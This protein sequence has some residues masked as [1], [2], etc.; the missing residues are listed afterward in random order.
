MKYSEQL[1]G[2]SEIALRLPNLLLLIMYM[3][4]SYLIFRK[5]S[6]LLT[7]SL[8]I[9]LCTNTSLLDFF[10]LA[11]GY[12]MSCG[13]MLMSLYH[14]IQSFDG[15]K[16]KNL[17]FFHLGALLA[18][19]SSFS[20]LPFYAT[21][22]MVYNILV[23]VDC[24]FILKKKFQ[25]LRENKIHGFS[26]LIVVP[27]L[28]EPVRRV[29]KFNHL[30]FGGKNGFFEDTVKNLINY[31]LNGIPLSS[32]A[33][34]IIQIVFTGIILIPFILIIRKI[35]LR[36]E[37]FFNNYK[38]LIISNFSII[39]ISLIL[40]LQH[41]ILGIDYPI[42]RF[43]IFLFPLFII[44]FGFL[45][46]Y[47]ISSGSKKL[48]PT[49]AICLVLLSL[50][51]IG[52]NANF[53]SCAEWQFDMETK[54]MIQK[55]IAQH[56]RDGIPAKKIKLGIN[57]LF[58]PSINFYRQTKNLIWLMPVDRKGITKEDDYYYIF[59]EDLN[60]LKP[61]AYEIVFEFPET[62]TLLLKNISN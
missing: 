40:I 22:L 57:W 11:R 36:N 13:F 60:Q 53:R 27:I 16:A 42:A 18:V 56:E 48:V 51:N 44:H 5:T 55:L 49:L 50:T 19:L 7:I 26:L 33:S 46:F 24:K 29:I 25:F 3:V 8:F 59:K 14:F 58:E 4:Y 9:I 17:V 61:D 30:D 41:L 28:F 35:F 47:F 23:F 43:S 10:G 12:G 1:F 32:F 38:G 62:N 52:L 21:L 20:L 45:L 37:M 31:C 54:N 6:P 39:G 2:S 34:T 15:Q